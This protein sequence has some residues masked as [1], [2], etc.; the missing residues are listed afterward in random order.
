MNET[1]VGSDAWTGSENAGVAD[2]K[3]KRYTLNKHN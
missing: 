1:N 3:T 2:V